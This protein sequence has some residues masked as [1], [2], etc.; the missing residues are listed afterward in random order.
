MEKTEALRLLQSMID[1]FEAGNQETDA[2]AKDILES[3]IDYRD[4]WRQAGEELRQGTEWTG[5]GR[6]KP[7]WSPGACAGSKSCWPTG[8]GNP[9]NNPGPVGPDRSTPEPG[10]GPVKE[11]QFPAAGGAVVP[12]DVDGAV[13]GAQLEITMIRG[14]PAVQDLEHLDPPALQ[15]ET[16]RSFLS[17]IAGVAFDPDF[18]AAFRHPGL[19]ACLS[20][21]AWAA[22]TSLTAPSP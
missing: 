3:D 10:S 12:Q 9:K 4:H 5:L 6:R 8:R 2:A 21:A 15:M 11:N 17:P 13:I 19:R 22:E 14:Q 20:A 16:A 18:D 7:N 1:Y